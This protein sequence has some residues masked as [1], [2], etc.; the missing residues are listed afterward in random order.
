MNKRFLAVVKRSAVMGPSS[1]TQQTAPMG[2]AGGQSPVQT[3]Q[4]Q[5]QVA[6]SQSGT[7]AGNPEVQKAQQASMQAQQ[8]AQQAA[9]DAQQQAQQQI[10]QSQQQAQG[11]V[12]QERQR[13]QKEIERLQGVNAK[14][15][16]D[17]L[18][19]RADAEIARV[20]A[21]QNAAK[22]QPPTGDGGPQ[23]RETSGR[24]VDQ[25]LKR[26]MNRLDKLPPHLKSAAGQAGAMPAYR[27]TREPVPR[28]PFPKDPRIDFGAGRRAQHTLYGHNDQMVDMLPGVYMKSLGPFEAFSGLADSFVYKRPQFMGKNQ[29]LAQLA[30]AGQYQQALMNSLQGISS[31]FGQTTGQFGI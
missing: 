15:Q 10:Q 19:A 30:L 2:G 20:K 3:I 29:Q 11:A 8:Q 18:K 17:A 9:M 28:A 21:E 25:R 22:I 6:Q 13:S 27:R 23:A 26:V 5:R 24:L 4:Q 14:L 16:A 7:P 31:G 1:L 12:E